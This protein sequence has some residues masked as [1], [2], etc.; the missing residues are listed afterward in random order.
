MK[1]N[2]IYLFNFYEKKYKLLYFIFKI[3]FINFEKN[4][5]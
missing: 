5:L 2:F 3:K 1:I 4:I